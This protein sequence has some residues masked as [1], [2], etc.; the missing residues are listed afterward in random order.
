MTDAATRL[1]P[2]PPRLFDGPPPL[3]VRPGD[4]GGSGMEPAPAARYRGSAR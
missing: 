1:A 3:R 2:L 4:A